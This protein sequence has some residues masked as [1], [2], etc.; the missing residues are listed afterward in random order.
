MGVS[1]HLLLG[2]RIQGQLDLQAGLASSAAAC[3]AGHPV[4]AA[5]AVGCTASQTWAGSCPQQLRQQGLTLAPFQHLFGGPTK[6]TW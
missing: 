3:A 5:P 1:S 6:G 2:A 4:S